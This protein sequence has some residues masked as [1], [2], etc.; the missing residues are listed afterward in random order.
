MLVSEKKV[1][2]WIDDNVLITL[3]QLSQ[4]DA[5]MWHQLAENETWTF[6]RLAECALRR[7]R[8]RMRLKPPASRKE[9]VA[10]LLEFRVKVQL[11]HDRFAELPQVPLCDFGG[12]QLFSS[13]GFR[14]MKM[15]Y[16]NEGGA[17]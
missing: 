17:A 1:K 8:E 11:V 4:N 2:R 12:Q 14:Q 10:F 15:M 3:D 6:F 9:V 13:P 7:R 16:A 5:N